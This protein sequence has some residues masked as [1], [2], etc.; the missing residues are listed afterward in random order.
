M[1]QIIHKTKNNFFTV[2]IL[3]TSNTCKKS[4]ILWSLMFDVCFFFYH[5]N[6]FL[7]SAQN[8]ISGSIFLS[9]GMFPENLN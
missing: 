4:K 1:R 9:P 3:L 5:P 8:G 7:I 6:D 2:G